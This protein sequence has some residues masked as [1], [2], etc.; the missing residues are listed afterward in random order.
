MQVTSHFS[1][2]ITWMPI[3][4]AKLKKAEVTGPAGPAEVA[5]SAGPSGPEVHSG[6]EGS[7]AG[8]VKSET[9]HMG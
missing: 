5:G 8:G 1:Y 6:P 2:H 4:R 3:F 9:G 7:P